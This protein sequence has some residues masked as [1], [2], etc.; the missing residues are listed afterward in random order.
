MIAKLGTGEMI[1]IETSF[2]DNEE[3]DI[4]N[5]Y[6]VFRRTEGEHLEQYRVEENVIDQEQ[7]DYWP[8]EVI[9]LEGRNEEDQIIEAAGEY[10]ATA[11]REEIQQIIKA[12][13]KAIEE[14]EGDEMLDYLEYNEEG[15]NVPVWEKVEYSFTVKE[16]AEEIGLK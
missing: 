2:L 5:P 1:G 3:G 14:G 7:L 8:K 6:V 12:V 16:F 10:L 15:D 4:L 9:H 11:D 13:K